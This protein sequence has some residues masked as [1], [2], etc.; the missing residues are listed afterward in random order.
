MGRGAE[1]SSWRCPK[2]CDPG[3]AKGCQSRV[4]RAQPTIKEHGPNEAL[5]I[6]DEPLITDAL[7]LKG[8][9]EEILQVRRARVSQ[10]KS[11]LDGA[12]NVTLL[13]TTIS[14]ELTARG[15]SGDRVG[16]TS[17][18]IQAADCRSWP[19]GLP[20]VTVDSS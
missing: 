5:P 20:L 9:G 11:T 1:Q 8:R 15:Q 12:K 14:G 17:P 16:L 19:V 18:S 6:I 13:C 10:D 4:Q 2:Q 7:L 3:S